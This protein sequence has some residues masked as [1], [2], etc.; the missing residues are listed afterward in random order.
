MY[1]YLSLLTTVLFSISI[2]FYSC[3]LLRWIDGG[4]WVFLVLVGKFSMDCKE[5]G[6][7]MTIRHK[8]GQ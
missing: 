2:V 7:G 8:T 5:Y 3:L 1:R 6:L 4:N